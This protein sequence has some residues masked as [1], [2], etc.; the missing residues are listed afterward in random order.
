MSHVIDTVY[1]NPKV[2]FHLPQKI[3]FGARSDVTSLQCS[4]WT[5]LLLSYTVCGWTHKNN[6]LYGLQLDVTQWY[7]WYLFFFNDTKKQTKWLMNNIMLR[8]QWGLPYWIAISKF[9][10]FL[11]TLGLEHPTWGGV[12]A[13]LE[14]YEHRG[15]YSHSL[16]CQKQ[17]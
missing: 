7:Q 15:P 1:S 13:D 9:S 2:A 5:Y 8:P 3:E 17:N 14:G 16:R 11:L 6:L 12:S 4:I 10:R